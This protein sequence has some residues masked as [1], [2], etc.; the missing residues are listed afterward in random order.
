MLSGSGSEIPEGHDEESIKL[1]NEH[2]D[3]ETTATPITSSGIEPEMYN[4]N[5]YEKEY[6]TTPQPT[7]QASDYLLGNERQE[8]ELYCDYR[9]RMYW[10]DLLKKQYFAGR[11]IWVGKD[12]GEI[13]NMER[14][15][16]TSRKLR[17]VE[18]RKA[19]KVEQGKR[20]P[21]DVKCRNKKS[22]RQF[23]EACKK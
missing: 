11:Q 10:Q 8:G 5:P 17:K 12:R 20:A 1:C 13:H 15:N 22:K 3:H 7:P 18:E 6:S 19:K 9:A 21:K 23:M 2:C 16:R 14:L 4:P